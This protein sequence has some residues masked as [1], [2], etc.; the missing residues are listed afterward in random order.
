LRF[1][2]LLLFCSL[3]LSCKSLD[4]VYEPNT[5]RTGLAN[6]PAKVAL[7]KILD[8]RDPLRPK[9]PKEES[10]YFLERNDKKRGLTHN[11]QAFSP[12]AQVLRDLISEE[13]LY[14]GVKA[15]PLDLFDDKGTSMREL[16]A[17]AKA[18]GAEYVLSAQLKAFSIVQDEPPSWLVPVLAINPYTGGLSDQAP[19]YQ[20]KIEIKFA[21]TR[22]SDA[23]VIWTSTLKDKK[24][25]RRKTLL[26]TQKI[27]FDMLS[28]LLVQAVYEALGAADKDYQRRNQKK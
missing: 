15:L 19:L 24:S 2:L 3:S 14:A 7:T 18:I 13:M 1:T 25:D 22:V 28:P 20:Y 26:K 10:D 9:V 8:L 17:E 12:P 16:A 11:E 23:A 6:T 27:M 4:Y 21:M 5:P